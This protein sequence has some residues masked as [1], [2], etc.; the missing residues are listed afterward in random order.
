MTCKQQNNFIID[1]IGY[2][3]LIILCFRLVPPI[4]ISICYK[5]EINIEKSF[6]IMEFLVCIF[7]MIYGKY[8]NIYIIVYSNS[9]VLGSIFVVCGYN[10]Y[11]GYAVSNGWRENNKQ[12]TDVTNLTRP[13]S[14]KKN[15]LK[16]KK[17]NH[18]NKKSQKNKKKRVNKKKKI[19]NNLNIIIK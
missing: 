15:L 19:N 9:I 2:I 1:I 13:T 18:K 10:S 11:H 5:K 8:Y 17:K 12:L 7:Y 14:S 6:L 4:F 3:A 16:I